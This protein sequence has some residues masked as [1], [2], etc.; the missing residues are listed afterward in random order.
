MGRT[1]KRKVNPEDKFDRTKRKERL[2][3]YV[4]EDAT[5]YEELF[6]ESSDTLYTDTY[7]KYENNT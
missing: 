1:Y 4:E 2:N 5:Y 7:E 3:K 6:D